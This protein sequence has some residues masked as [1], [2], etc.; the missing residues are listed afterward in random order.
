MHLVAVPGILLGKAEREVL[1][2]VGRVATHLN[3]L[4]IE[5]LRCGKELTRETGN[6]SVPANSLG[7]RMIHCRESAGAEIT[8]NA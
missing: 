5:A 1:E 7:R 3:S 8:T 4:V 6:V 2:S